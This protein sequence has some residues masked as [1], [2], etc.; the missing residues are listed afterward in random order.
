MVAAEM[1]PTG[2]G[3]PADRIIRGGIIIGLDVARVPVARVDWGHDRAVQKGTA[4]AQG[5]VSASLDV[6]R[7]APSLPTEVT[8]ARGQVDDRECI[9]TWPLG[10]RIPR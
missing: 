4:R 7:R 1:R 2:V 3:S 9:G 5:G 6:A 8:E 10:G